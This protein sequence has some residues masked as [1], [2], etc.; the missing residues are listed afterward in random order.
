MFDPYHKWLAIPPGPQP[1]THYQL[2]GISPAEKD[3][4]V[5]EEAVLQRT[6]H[7]RTYQIGP[8][9]KEC[10]R[11]LNEIAQA[12]IVLLNPAK[13]LEYDA[14]LAEQVKHAERSQS[15]AQA[16]GPHSPRTLPIAAGIAGCVIVVVVVAVMVNG[17]SRPAEK[18][19]EVAKANPAAD[20]TPSKDYV[21][22]DDALPEGAQLTKQSKAWLW[23]Q[24]PEF[25]VLSGLKSLKGSGSGQ[26]SRF[27]HGA[28]SHL[29]IAPGD[30]LFAYVWLDPKDPPESVMLQFYDG[31]HWDHRAYWGA[32]LCIAKGEPDAPHHRHK[33][34]LPTP[35]QWTRLEVDPQEVGLGAGSKVNGLGFNQFGGTAYFDKPGINTANP[36]TTI[37]G[38]SAVSPMPTKKGKKK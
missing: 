15:K 22:F 11:L 17:G 3:A 30:R 10:T 14:Q 19:D 26:Q 25:P 37:L 12:K 8:R 1:P 21:W 2:L 27:F 35:G 20:P 29:T 36:P 4:E 32:D 16:A 38:E 6:A 7:L 33:G 34:P 5:I 24:A 9:A 23:V 28:A 18:K 13:R 31:K